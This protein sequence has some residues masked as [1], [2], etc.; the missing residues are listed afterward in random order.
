[1]KSRKMSEDKKREIKIAYIGGGSRDWG[2]KFM[3][4]LALCPNLSG[5]LVLYD[6]D[7]EAA[8]ANV[9]LANLLF[10]H[11]EAKT[12]FRVRAAKTSKGA[13]TGADFVVMS[14]EP[15]PIT[16]RY[17]D[18]EIPRAYGII[19]S[20]GDTTGPG[21][22]L[23]ALRAVPI[24]QHYAHQIMEYCPNSWV[25]SYT[26]PMTICTATLSTVE[27]SIKAFGCCHE[28]FSTQEML[29]GLV[30]KWFAVPRPDRR[31][32]RL[33]LAG[34]NHFTFATAA[35]WKGEDLFPRLR[36]MIG[37]E[38]FFNDHTPQALHRLENHLWFDHD[39]LIAFDF[40]ARFGVLGAAGD[41]HLAE[42]VPWYLSIENEL[43]RWG[44]ILTPYSWRVERMSRHSTRDLQSHIVSSGE[45]GVTQILALLGIKHLTTNVNY[46]NRGQ[47]PG[48]ETGAVVETFALF[49]DN[50]IR[51]LVS[52]SLPAMVLSL[53]NHVSQI[54]KMTL[55]AALIRS[56]ELAF[57]A[58]L[59]DP[60]VRIPTD[61]AW[62][63]FEEMLTFVKDTLPDWSL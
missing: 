59:N 6:I 36:Q 5:E 14:I 62:A 32:I 2:P 29:A 40:L 4:D 9:R 22:I 11:P 1:L 46:P 56:K 42:F 50:E 39:S 47:H 44:V 48:L 16:M 55:E 41:R 43:H 28:V 30:E 25:I 57:Q 34:I 26:N 20:V 51:P 18:L 33:D 21:G 63:M 38:G 19:Q 60:L 53:V 27:P 17:A 15:S 35:S 12:T 24:Y 8:L 3:T 10:A 7:S 31:E 61:Q 13:L 58:L 49:T 54:Q 37:E 23:R 45:E 52:K